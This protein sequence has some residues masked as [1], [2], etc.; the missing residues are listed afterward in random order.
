MSKEAKKIIRRFSKGEVKD[1]LKILKE[2]SKQDFRSNELLSLYSE[3]LMDNRGNLSELAMEL[4]E[5]LNE[6]EVIFIKKKFLRYCSGSN[7]DLTMAFKIIPQLWEKKSKLLNDEYLSKI[8]EKLTEVI[9]KRKSNYAES[10]GTVLEKLGEDKGTIKKIFEKREQ[11]ILERKD[12]AID[13][14]KKRKKKAKWEKREYDII[15]IVTFSFVG[16][17]GLALLTYLLIKVTKGTLIFLGICGLIYSILSIFLYR[18]PK[19]KRFYARKLVKKSYYSTRS[20]RVQ[21]KDVH[22]NT[23]STNR[24]RILHRYNYKCRYCDHHWEE[25]R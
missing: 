22:G 9:I 3:S 14:E 20:E 6:D 13:S 25:I 24:S 23:I 5:K 12:K 17:V 10:A 2:V 18:C 1:K 15:V 19:C 8:K 4:I 16:L 7:K 11:N 21:T